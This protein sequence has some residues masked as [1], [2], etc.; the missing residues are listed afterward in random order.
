MRCEAPPAPGSVFCADHQPASL[1]EQRRA[2]AAI[3]PECRQL[4]CHAPRLTGG[5]LCAEHQAHLDQVRADTETMRA[6]A[7]RHQGGQVAIV[8]PHCQVKGRVTTR[9]VKQKKGISGGKAVGAIFTGGTSM[10]AT[11]LSRKEKATEMH[12]HNCNTTWFI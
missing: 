9:R 5:D 2:R 3:V 10:L 4:D 1:E 12:C 6:F 8:C 7:A 11:G